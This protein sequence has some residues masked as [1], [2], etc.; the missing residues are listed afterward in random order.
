[1]LFRSGIQL[2]KG[3]ITLLESRNNP[4]GI[5]NDLLAYAEANGKFLKEEFTFTNEQGKEAKGEK[6]IGYA[7]NDPKK[8]VLVITD[9]LRKI[10]LERIGGNPANLKQCIDKYLEY[11]V[12]LRNLCGYS[13]L[14]IIH[15]NRS[16]TDPVRMKQAG[17]LLYPNGDDVKDSGN[18]SEEADFMFT[19]FNPNDERYNLTKHFGDQIKDGNGNELYPNLRSLHLVENRHGDAPIHWR[20]NMFGNIKKFEHLEIT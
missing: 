16:I 5:R 8:F 10:S 13:F 3:V 9:H 18:L 6:K 2:E 14:H 7:P 12:E 1:M 17:D 20:L 4:T 11:S 15:L 19:L